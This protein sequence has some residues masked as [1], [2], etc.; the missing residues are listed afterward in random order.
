M[1]DNTPRKAGDRVPPATFKIREGG[2]W[3][4]RTADEIFSG[5]TVVVFAL[6]GAFTPTCSSAH[7][8]GYVALAPKF[9]EAGVDE[10]CCL[11]VNDSFVMNA[12]AKDQGVEGEVTMLPDGNADFTAGM[13]MLV[14]KRELGFGNR[15]WRY[16]MLVRDGVIERIFVEDF[17]DKGDPFA[18]S[19]A[20]TMLRYLTEAK[21][22]AE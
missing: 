5:R 12:W 21:A 19:D 14:S 6:P 18:V 1:T 22:A 3:T 10:I 13:G 4:E 15:S 8:P 2:A 9:K 20:P 16:S 17:N 11:S 7:L